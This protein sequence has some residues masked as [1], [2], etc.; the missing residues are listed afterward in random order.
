MRRRHV[1]S[2][3]NRQ[4]HQV[5]IGRRAGAEAA[6]P[7]ANP[8]H[9]GRDGDRAAVI[10]RY[11]RWLWAQ[12][13]GQD[14]TVCSELARLAAIGE[15]LEVLCWCHPRQACHGDIVLAAVAWTRRQTAAGGAGEA[16][17]AVAPPGS[18]EDVTLTSRQITRYVLGAD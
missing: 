14:P 1:R 3:A 17:E 15:R 10:A 7:L 8:Y 18:Y 12:I 13:R 6:S 2:V 9:I 4:A 11:R 16:P 5:Y